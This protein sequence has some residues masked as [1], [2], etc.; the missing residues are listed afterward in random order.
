[1]LGPDGEAVGVWLG[2][3]GLGDETAEG[4]TVGVVAVSIVRK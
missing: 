1:M 4:V 2:P 3:V